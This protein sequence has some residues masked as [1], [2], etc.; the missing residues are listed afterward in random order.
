MEAATARYAP[1]VS[2]ASYTGIDPTFKGA[3]QIW[4]WSSGV[5]L[6]EFATVF[7]GFGRHALSPNGEWYVCANWRKGRNGGVACHNARTG[8]KIWHR[9]DLRQVQGIRFSASGDKVWC[10]VDARP[11]HCLD[12]RSGTPLGT[13]RNV[14]DVVESPYSDLALHS[15]R[16]ADYFLVGDTS[17]TIP[18]I[19][20]GRLSDAAFSPESLC[21]A[22]YSGFVRCIDCETGNERWRYV[23]PRGFHV[24]TLSHQ[25]DDAFY[26]YLFGYEFPEA[27]LLRFSPKSGSCAEICRYDLSKRSG[28]GF[29]QGVF[30]S[31]NGE[32]L[33]LVDGR[34]VRQLPFPIREH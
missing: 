8:E 26:G 33:S 6:S 22:E 3:A 21:L 13:I 1:I 27:A 7:D 19:T 5:R 18:R 29:G 25:D 32:V 10:R 31:G 28:G 16:R 17:K 11:V 15:R 4:N 2:A 23:P 20:P 12:S 24:I 34:V 14:D 30:V 9:Q